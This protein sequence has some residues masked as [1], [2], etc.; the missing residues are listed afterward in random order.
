MISNI[1]TSLLPLIPL[2]LGIYLVFLMRTDFDLG[3]AGTF[4]V[5]GAISGALLTHGTPVWV[6]I[7]V[8]IAVAAGLGVV[9]SLLYWWLRIP[10]FLGGLI[11]AIA[12]YSVALSIMGSNATIS[13]LGVDTVL[14]AA[15]AP[16]ALNHSVIIIVI[17]A[18]FAAAS[19]IV[20]GWFL[21]TQLGLA[22]RVSGKNREM[23]RSNGFDDKLGI[24]IS[25]ALANG[26][27]GLSGSLTAQANSYVTAS[28]N[29][30]IIIAGVGAIVVG[31]L[32]VRPDSSH[33]VRVV[34]AVLI[35]GIIY[36]TVII[37]ALEVGV[38]PTYTNLITGL[39]LIAAIAV[40]LL[41]RKTGARIRHRQVA[42]LEV[43]SD[44]SLGELSELLTGKKN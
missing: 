31:S 34:L 22:V 21:K 16:S 6:A 19:V 27:A 1:L 28:V 14:S 17:L 23:S 12:L 32:I 36:E 33:I 8:S 20:I 10:V 24:L 7:I 2:Y 9:T 39:T 26:L 43:F 18:A 42:D 41:V 25:L 38:D 37:G 15:G 40:Q 11:M 29:A 4:G 13:L 3:V 44:K 30:P 5:G 35:G